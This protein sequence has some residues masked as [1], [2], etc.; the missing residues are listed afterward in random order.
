MKSKIMYTVLS[1]AMFMILSTAVFAKGPED[2]DKDRGDKSAGA[3]YTMTNAPGGNEVVIFDRDHDGALTKA[4]TVS[5]GGT[6]SG[7]GLDPLG[8]Q[9]SIVLSRDNQWLLAVNGGSNEISVFQVG[10]DGLKLTD[11]VNSGGLLPV[12]LTDYHDLVY[13]L[14]A[15]SSPNIA[16]FKLD[17]K[18]RLTP[19]A[20]STRSLASNGG[21][22][23]VGFDPKGET[24]VVTDKVGGKI[25]VYFVNDDGF[26][27]VTPVTSISNG[28]TPFGFIFD[29]RGRLLVA[30]A[31]SN[32]VS[33]YKILSNDTL[34]VISGSVPNGQKAPCWIVG[35]GVGDVFT[36]NP[37][38]GTFSSYRLMTR[39]GQ[40]ALVDGVSGNGNKP[41][42]VAITAD[43]R[44]LYALDPGN[45]GIDMFRIE[46]DG[47][48]TNLSAIDG[49]LSLFA[50]GIAAR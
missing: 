3:V 50:Q 42:D 19:L 43:G 9:N 33:S 13:V 38:N 22:A 34:Q 7:G 21:Y 25:L 10:P 11:K 5:T 41:L 45:G 35:D 46:H 30:E 39:N 8:S 40:V 1:I 26:P 15:G 6:G 12:S 47:G 23:Q 49:E 28:M 14:N 20:G 16:G 24:L 4:G 48:L 44:F 27:A 32:A 36:A 17:H 29:S 2:K 18:G 37:G 31:G